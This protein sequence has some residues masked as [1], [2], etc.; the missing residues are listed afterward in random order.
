MDDGVGVSTYASD[1]AFAQAEHLVSRLRGLQS[2]GR[3]L[4]TRVGPL[5]L[6]VNPQM[7]GTGAGGVGLEAHGLHGGG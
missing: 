1:L 6:S 3:G 7:S 5:L 2:D 4:F